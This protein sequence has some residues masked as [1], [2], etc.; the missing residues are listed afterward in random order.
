M[1]FK[2]MIGLKCL[3]LK[4]EDIT[5]LAV[6]STIN[7]FMFLEV[8]KTQIRSIRVQLKESILILKI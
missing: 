5:I 4:K 6:T 7:L 1:I 2:L 3:R 8:F